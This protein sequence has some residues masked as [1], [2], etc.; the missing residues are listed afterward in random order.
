MGGNHQW[1]AGKFVRSLRIEL[2]KEHLG[3]QNQD[4]LI[5]SDPTDSVI[6]CLWRDC[7][8]Q[9]SDTYQE[10][11]P[12]LPS[13]RI[14]TIKQYLMKR[15]EYNRKMEKMGWLQTQSNIEEFKVSAILTNP[16]SNQESLQL[17]EENKVDILELQDT[18]FSEM[19]SLDVKQETEDK[20]TYIASMQHKLSQIRGHLVVFPTRFLEDER[21]SPPPLSLEGVMPKY[22][23]Q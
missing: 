10:V 21:L 1:C 4:I 12:Y 2:W 18:L 3:I 7:A 22:V 15:I 8:T 19:K 17:G 14:K 9:N 16:N 11:F 5:E 20:S 13:D 6:G 23:F